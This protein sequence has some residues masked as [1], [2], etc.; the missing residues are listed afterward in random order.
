MPRA[1][2]LAGAAKRLQLAKEKNHLFH[3]EKI[4]D[5]TQ[6]TVP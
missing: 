4:L 6:K 5:D 2:Y 1:K 3:L